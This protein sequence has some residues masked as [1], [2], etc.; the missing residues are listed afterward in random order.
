MASDESVIPSGKHKGRTLGSMSKAEHHFL[1]AS[2]NGSPKLKA[3]PFFQRIL[4]EFDRFKVPNQ[5]EIHSDTKT[6][7]VFDDSPK[8]RLINQSKQNLQEE[9]LMPFGKHRGEQLS[10]VPTAYIEWCLSTF[11]SDHGFRETLAAEYTRRTGTPAPFHVRPTRQ[12]NDDSATHYQWADF[13]G[14][15]H[16]IPNDVSMIGRES[17]VCPF[18]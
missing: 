4:E 1:W 11:H 6:H 9:V 13:S 12:Q 7:I 15:V 8:L 16:K 18:V 2:W 17:E 3:S 10:S 14:F 5:T